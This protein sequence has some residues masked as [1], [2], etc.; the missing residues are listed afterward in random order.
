[1]QHFPKQPRGSRTC[2]GKYYPLFGKQTS[3]GSQFRKDEHL[4]PF[5]VYPAGARVRPLLQ[6]GGW[7][8]ACSPIMGTT[9]TE[10]RLRKRGYIPFLEYY[11][12]VKYGDTS[13][14]KP[15]PNKS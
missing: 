11:L 12:R 15:K 1:L 7:A 4:P 2:A 9:V 6:K 5:Q 14:P 13:K 8:I 3:T 10:E